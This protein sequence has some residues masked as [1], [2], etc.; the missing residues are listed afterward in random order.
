MCSVWRK[1]ALRASVYEPAHFEVSPFLKILQYF[2][3]DPSKPF[4]ENETISE[5]GFSMESRAIG[6]L[7]HPMRKNKPFPSF[8]YWCDPDFPTTNDIQRRF[9]GSAVLKIPPLSPTITSF[10]VQLSVF[11]DVHSREFWEFAVKR[12]PTPILH[13][14]QPPI[15]IVSNWK[16]TDDVTYLSRQETDRLPL[17]P[18]LDDFI[19][20]A[21]ELSPQDREALREP[22]DMANKMIESCKLIKNYWKSSNELNTSIAEINLRQ[23][24][25][26]N[27]K[28]TIRNKKEDL[29]R[30]HKAL[31]EW[32]ALLEEQI[33]HL[34]KA[35]IAH[36]GRIDL[37]PALEAQI[38]SSFP[39]RREV[40]CNFN[41]ET[42]VFAREI[43]KRLA[44][45]RLSQQAKQ[46]LDKIDLHLEISRMRLYNPE[47]PNFGDTDAGQEISII[48]DA[49]RAEEAREFEI[50]RNG[51]KTYLKLN[52]PSQSLFFRAVLLSYF[53]MAPIEPGEDFEE[54]RKSVEGHELVVRT[55]RDLTDPDQCPESWKNLLIEGAEVAR[56]ALIIIEHQMVV[57]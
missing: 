12:F 55:L 27:L 17:M 10:P 11:E 33:V 49:K 8:G 25:A 39:G 4:I 45:A 3:I 46:R 31:N 54:L 42:R 47:D 5:I 16:L 48:S 28:N 41:K 20:N 34:E 50:L 52:D 53:A 35:V 30:R 57:N 43:R 40:H 18:D 14:R 37:L 24:A 26:S 1:S 7:L 6:G 15:K 51:C 32:I 44:R 19:Y 13:F 9:A 56:R 22:Y 36:R 2:I 38:I 21:M 23:S 29:F